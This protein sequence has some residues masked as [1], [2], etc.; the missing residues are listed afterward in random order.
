M[1]ERLPAGR[2]RRSERRRAG[3]F[4][5]PSITANI[6]KISLGEFVLGEAIAGTRA[7]L[8]AEARL[9]L[10]KDPTQLDVSAKIDGSTSPA[11]SRAT[12]VFAPGENR[13]EVNVNASEPAGGLVATL[14]KI[15]GAPAVE[16]HREGQGPLS[17]F[18]ANGALTVG[19]DTAATLTAQVTDT[20]EGRRIAASLGVSA[21][22]YVPNTYAAYVDGGVDLDAQMLL[23]NDGVDRHRPGLARLRPHRRQASGTYDGAAPATP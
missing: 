1:L 5:L 20:G 4:S 8:S 6:Q 17:D 9:G 7:R 19:A 10:A 23:R 3:G 16:P 21:E 2:P 15:P 13:L 18:M 12:L 22:R 14:L 11:R